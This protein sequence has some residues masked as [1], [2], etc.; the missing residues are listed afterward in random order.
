MSLLPQST[1]LGNLDIIEVYVYY[2]Q[3][4]LFSCKNSTDQLFLAVWVD[5]TETTN[6]WLYLPMSGERFEE[7]RGEKLDLHDAF[8]RS[9]PGFVYEVKID[10]HESLAWVETIHCERLDRDWLPTPGEFLECGTAIAQ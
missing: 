5:E 3:P 4:C 8:L 1:P 6:L 9:E 2:D 7:I 10:K